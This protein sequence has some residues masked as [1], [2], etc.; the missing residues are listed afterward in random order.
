M[1]AVPG[2]IAVGHVVTFMTISVDGSV[3]KQL[4]LFT[5]LVLDLEGLSINGCQC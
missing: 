4:S 2:R 1:V 5:C 3:L